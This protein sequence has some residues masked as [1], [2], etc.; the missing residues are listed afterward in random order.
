MSRIYRRVKLSSYELLDPA[1]TRDDRSALSDKVIGLQKKWND[2]CRLHQ[3]Q[4]FPK[5]DISHT[6]HGTGFALDHERSGEEPSSVTGERFVIGNPCLSRDLQNNLN[7]KQAR[8][9][10]ET[11]D[12][13]TDNFQSNMVTGGASPGE[14]ESLGIFSKSVVPK[15]HLHSDKLL[16]SSFISVTTDLGLGTLYASASDNK[17]KVG[18]LESQKHSIQHLTASNQTEYNRPSNNNPGQ[19]LGFERGFD[20][21]EF[22]SLWNALNEKVSWQGKA[23]SCIVETILR[24]RTGGGRRRSSNSRGDIWLTFLGP[25]MIGKRKISLALAELMFGSRE[26]LISVDFGSQDSDRRPNSLFDCQVLNGYDERFRGQTVV[27]YVA[28]ELRKKPSSVVLLENIHK[29]DVRAKSCLSQAITTGKFPD[30]HGR[31]FTINNTIFVTTLT[32]K[33]VDK[34]SNLDGDEQTEFSEERV[35][36]ARN[37]QMQILVQGFT[38][39]V[40]KCNDMNVRITSAPRGCLNLSLFK[41]RKLD[42][43]STELKKTSSSSMS[44]LDLNLPLEEVEDGP[45]DGDCDSDLVSEGSEAWVEEFLEQ[46][47]EKVMFKPYDF[48]EAAEKLVKEINLQFRRVFG[49]EVVLEIDYKIVVQIL[50]ANWVSE[51]KRGMEEWLELVLHRSFVE[52]EQKYQMGCGSVMK[53]MCK[54]DCAMEDQAPGI[55]LPATIKLN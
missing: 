33:M 16:P 9:I 26:N 14:A 47:D 34:T 17:R 13:H 44:F 4:M 29:A 42:D 52:A 31:Q 5:L 12:S 10:S 36:T 30:S 23:T 38:S 39:D 54:E 27:D 49:S 1:Q 46:V 24:C 20:M 32:N 11:S 48:E 15:G 55:S 8:Q 28:G 19:S 2:I 35:L 6:R 51:K 45:N 21:R 43:E 37:C 3:R 53:L 18:D 7:T 22:K 41:K 25:D 50:A 40:R